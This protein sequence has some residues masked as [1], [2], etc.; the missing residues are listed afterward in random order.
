MVGNY[1]HC[2]N[3]VNTICNLIEN[4]L[5]RFKKIVTQ[6]SFVLTRADKRVAPDVLD[7]LIRDFI[8]TVSVTHCFVGTTGY[9]KLF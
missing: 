1:S 7:F 5:P 8:C 2:F 6:I 9:T 4:D 3:Q